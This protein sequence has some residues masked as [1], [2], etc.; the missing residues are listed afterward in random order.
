MLYYLP[1]FKTTILT[2]PGGIN[3]S[4]T[5]GIK[6]QDVTGVDISKPGVACLSYTNP[7]NTDNAEFI[8]YTSIDG[9]NTA[10]GVTR[11]QEGISAKAHDNG[12]TVGF[13]VSKSHINNINDLLSG[14]TEG[15]KVKT[16]IQDENGNEVI[17]MPATASAVNE[18]TVTNA[19]TANAP[20]ISATGGDTN[21][22]LKLA[23]K[24][25]GVVKVM[26]GN[27]NE[28]IKGATTASAVN[29]LTATNAA[30]TGSPELSS[31]GDDTNISLSLTPKGTGVIKAKTTVQLTAFGPTTDVAT[32]DG[33]VGL[34]VPKEL[35][36]FNLV[37][38]AGCVTT[39]GTTGTEDI[40][41]RR[42]RS[43]TPQDMLSTKI[44]IDS[45]EVDSST[46]A[47]PAAINA[48]YD[49]ILEG[50]QIYIDIDA[51]HTTAAKGTMVHL[52]FAK[53]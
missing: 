30:T 14:V 45:A 37:A 51:K 3:D 26:D 47:T 2:T 7:L 40:Q 53:P 8:T 35:D 50:D 1:Q 11:A 15:I 16:S 18:V 21:I 52:T 6:F 34:R 28:V 31:T 33:K 5:A 29:E 19:A 27:G 43:A 42:V 49:D 25:T 20:Q 24:G 17:K 41:I 10:V 13:V 22:D 23:G 9:T 39:A 36:G 46:A 44:T 32:G 12:V 48:T 38:V 4:T